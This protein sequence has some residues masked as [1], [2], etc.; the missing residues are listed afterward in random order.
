[1]TATLDKNTSVTSP[2]TTP[3]ASTT[4]D[5]LPKATARYLWAL[6]RLCLARLCG[7]PSK[8]SSSASRPARPRRRVEEP[9]LPVEKWVLTSRDARLRSA[10]PT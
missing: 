1:M 9:V 2:G 5:L 4:A 3:D 8:A 6:T 7:H 10:L